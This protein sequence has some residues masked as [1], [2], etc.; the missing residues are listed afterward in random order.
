MKKAHLIKSRLVQFSLRKYAKYCIFIL[1]DI[2]QYVFR[3]F[4]R[5]HV[6]ISKY[7]LESEQVYPKGINLL[8]VLCNATKEKFR[9]IELT[10]KTPV[11]S[12][13]SCFAEEFAFY[14]LT[15]ATSLD[16]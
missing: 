3:R 13:G 2:M 12:I 4:P 14:M 1:D 15:K 5:K 7:N 9:S 6:G 8:P 16:K 11:C 10:P